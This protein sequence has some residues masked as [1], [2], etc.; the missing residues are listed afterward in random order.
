MDMRMV[1]DPRSTM[2]YFM[3]RIKTS[4]FV[5]DAVSS[6]VPENARDSTPFLKKSL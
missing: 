2:A 4:L 1:L 5:M 6:I 3:S